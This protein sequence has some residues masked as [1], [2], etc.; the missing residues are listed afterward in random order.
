MGGSGGGGGFFGG[1]DP[2]EVR[3]GLEQAIK[4]T[5][6]KALEIG[7][8]KEI[9]RLLAFYNDR[10]RQK[11]AEY[12]AD[13][14]ECA[15]DTIEG[16]ETILFGGSV[17]KHTYIDGVSDV[18]SL[19]LVNREDLTGYTPGDI[20]EELA[21]SLRAALPK[22]R[23]PDIR[24]GDLAI[25]VT[26]AD[27]TEIQVLP[28]ARTSSGFV[29]PDD[30]GA[31]WRQINPK[32]F[33]S[34]LTNANAKLGRA[35]IPTIKLAK[36]VISGLPESLKLSGYHVE[37]LALKA[38]AG[39][40]GKQ[41]YPEMLMHFFRT[42]SELVQRPTPDITGQSKFIDEDLGPARSTARRS[43]SAALSRIARRLENAT[44]VEEWKSILDPIE[45]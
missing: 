4:E 21:S 33:S 11:I 5:A 1:A 10:D 3:K 20:L 40:T 8:D 19:L 12:L 41:S 44:T 29:I 16:T 9:G 45:S 43:A 22:E 15:S 34:D 28:A 39:Y 2:E 18:D 25:T 30:K 27:G 26:Y 17:A 7:L 42:A 31:R 38:F 37:A 14:E 36:S 24:T 23:V 6:R 13:I 32:E 35:L